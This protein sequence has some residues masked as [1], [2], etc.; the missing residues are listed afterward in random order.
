MESIK[1]NE[2][3]PI[4]GYAM[5]MSPNETKQLS[6]VPTAWITDWMETGQH[7]NQSGRESH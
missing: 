7:S 4:S 6:V 5:L 1:G 3:Q 2:V